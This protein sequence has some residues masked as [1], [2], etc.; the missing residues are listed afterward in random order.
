[1]E[2]NWLIKER[3]VDRVRRV[4]ALA[5]PKC[6]CSCRNAGVGMLKGINL[7]GRKRPQNKLNG[8]YNN[9]VGV[10]NQQGGNHFATYRLLNQHITF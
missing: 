8:V 7:K 4:K 2:S 10:N 1:M 3:K 5:G 9:M 6:G